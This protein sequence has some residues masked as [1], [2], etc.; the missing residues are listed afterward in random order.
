MKKLIAIISM[1]A[2]AV[3]CSSAKKALSQ[4]DLLAQAKTLAVQMLTKAGVSNITGL[5]NYL[6]KAKDVVTSLIGYGDY[7]GS[8]VR[9]TADIDKDNKVNIDTIE[10]PFAALEQSLVKKYDNVSNVFITP[11]SKG[12]DV[13]FL[14]K[15]GSI[16]KAQFAEMKSLVV[17]GIKK[18]LPYAEKI[19]VSVEDESTRETIME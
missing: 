12:I 8:K 19:S 4:E 15:P 16:S 7:N 13:A 14:A 6:P 5:T 18:Q 9:V 11:Y 10:A 3:S 2:V 17:E 1:A